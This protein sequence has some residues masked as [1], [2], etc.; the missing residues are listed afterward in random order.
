MTLVSG[1]SFSP[2]MSILIIGALLYNHLKNKRK[3]QNR[4]G[5]S[6]TEKW[7]L[8]NIV[9]LGTVLTC[10]ISGIVYD[11][12][13]AWS[14]GIPY[15]IITPNPVITLLLLPTIV[16]LLILTYGKGSEVEQ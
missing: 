4:L 6:E 15:V 1:L 13:E 9:T 16:Y 14:L 12:W 11:A 8:F 5:Y 2:L 10:F 7:A 3:E